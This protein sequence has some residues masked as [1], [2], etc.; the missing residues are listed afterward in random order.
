M[1]PSPL[2][3]QPG[4]DAF[5]RY[6]DGVRRVGLLEERPDNVWRCRLYEADGESFGHFIDVSAAR[7]QGEG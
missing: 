5:I 4:D 1:T 6:G 2:E 7:L 3:L